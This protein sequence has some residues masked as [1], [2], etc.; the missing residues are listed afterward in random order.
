MK[1][2]M[3][4]MMAL[5]VLGA[6][7]TKKTKDDKTP[8]QSKEQAP[9]RMTYDRMWEYSAH[10][11]SEDSEYIC[12]VLEMITSFKKGEETDIVT[13]DFTDIITFYYA[14]DTSERFVFEENSLV[15][16]EKRYSVEGN[17]SGLRGLLEK[18]LEESE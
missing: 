2:M 1:K 4:L 14:D 17:L 6:C 8:I 11:E 10:A 15:E 5:L 13:E 16:N 18:C 3:V 12:E 9:V 7:S